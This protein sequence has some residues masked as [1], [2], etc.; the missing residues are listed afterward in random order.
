MLQHQLRKIGVKLLSVVLPY[1]SYRL[2]PQEYLGSVDASV[3]SVINTL[4]DLGYHYQ[5]FSARK[6]HPTADTKDAGSFSRIPAEHPEVADG[7]AL[8]QKEPSECQY[9]IQL[10]R[11]DG[12]VEIYCHYEIHPYLLTPHFSFSRLQ[13]HYSPTRTSNTDDV[14]EFT[15]IEGA[16]DERVLSAF[17]F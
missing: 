14:S 17:D 6:T 15:Y 7:T 3:P 1:T 10:F 12:E 11:V 2:Q 13:R 4:N 16:A 5:M 9:H 8:A